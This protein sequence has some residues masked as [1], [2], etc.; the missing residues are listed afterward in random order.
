MELKFVLPPLPSLEEIGSGNK[1][2]VDFKAVKDAMNVE[3]ALGILGIGGDTW[4]LEESPSNDD[5]LIGHCPVCEY[6]K[7]HSFCV[8]KEKKVYICHNKQCGSKGSILDLIVNLTDYDLKQAGALVSGN[9]TTKEDVE[10]DS[11]YITQFILPLESAITKEDR[12]EIK[13]DEWYAVHRS[14][15]LELHTHLSSLLGR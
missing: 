7:K 13:E 4:P 15:L 11:F 5:E 2:T 12:G 10:Q 3:I 9:F 1:I 8:N 6:E 14:T